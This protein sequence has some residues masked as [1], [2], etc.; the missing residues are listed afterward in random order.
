M[1]TSADKRAWLIDQGYEVKD[2]GKLPAELEAAYAAAHPGANGDSS[3]DYP[4]G[5]SDSDFDA[6][7]A[8]ADIPAGLLDDLD[9]QAA[10]SAPRRPARRAAVP[11]RKS[12]PWSRGQGKNG[13]GRSRGRAR[14]PRVS[15]EDLI[16]GGWR[17]MARMARPVPP[18]A[19]TLRVQAPVAGL[20][21]DD[22][23]KDSVLDRMLQPLAR[24]QVQGKVVAALAGPPVLVTVI[25][26]HLAQAQAAGTD[27]NPVFMNAASEMLRESLI[28]WMDVAGPKFEAALARERAFE[29]HYG[30]EVDAFM[31]WLFAPPP[32]PADAAAMEAE[33]AQLRRAQ[34][35]H[36]HDDAVAGTMAG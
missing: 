20:L 35:L 16:C 29:E 14:K 21:L 28:I 12:W 22:A 19:R 10:E 34:G 33:E 15:V 24:A 5:M 27:P 7:T 13:R 6:V 36:D 11:A 1:A 8:G 17:I 4:A 26:M 30:Q 32:D 9:D 31:G 25:S 23:V 3:A 18:L 2:R